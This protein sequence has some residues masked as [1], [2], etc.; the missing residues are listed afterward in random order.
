MNL[1]K[2]EQL[3]KINTRN[4]QAEIYG[5]V[6]VHKNPNKDPLLNAE[7]RISQGT[8]GY[9]QPSQEESAPFGIQ[10]V[11]QNLQ[12]FGEEP[13]VLSYTAQE[14]QIQ[15]KLRTIMNEIGDQQ[16]EPL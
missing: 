4:D 6:G 11:S 1:F 8:F 10:Q 13:S 2:D 15:Q 14:Q 3:R 12:S 5:A 16:L 9:P 7:N